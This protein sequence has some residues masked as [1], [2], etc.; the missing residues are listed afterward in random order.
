MKEDKRFGF[1]KIGSLPVRAKDADDSEMVSQLLFGEFFEL[2]SLSEKP[3]WIKIRCHHDGYEGFI[4]PK[5]AGWIDE[6][7]FNI[8]IKRAPQPTSKVFTPAYFE[9]KLVKI[10]QSGDVRILGKKEGPKKI[11]SKTFALSYLGTPYLWG[12]RSPFGID[13][14][15]FT[16]T[17]FAYKNKNIPRDASQQVKLGQEV[18]YEQQRLWDLVFFKN[19]TDKI[20]HVGIIMAKNEVLHAHGE[21]KISLLTEEGLLDDKGENLTHRFASIKRI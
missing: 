2:V 7:L 12:G 4:D 11:D 5:Q 17:V 3:N 1:C 6:K 21:V 8:Y 13:C 10:P 18:P 15:G 9:K 20:I 19:D 14:S 16:Q